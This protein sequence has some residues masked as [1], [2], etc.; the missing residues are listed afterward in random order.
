MM[1]RLMQGKQGNLTTIRFLRNHYRVADNRDA[2][3]GHFVERVR[4]NLHVVLCMSPVGDKL[5]NRYSVVSVVVNKNRCRMF[6]SL[7]NCCTIDW[8]DAWPKEALLAVSSKF[9]NDTSVGEPQLS[10]NLA[11]M[12]FTIHLSVRDAAQRMQDELLRRFY[13]T[14]ATYLDFINNCIN[15]C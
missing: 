12:C 9:L 5:R 1:S 6:P 10:Q 2:I 15:I 14:P 4:Q 8:F 3:F 7:V 13:V 11:Q